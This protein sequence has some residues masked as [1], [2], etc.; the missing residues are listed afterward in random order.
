MIGSAL[1]I[2]A[3][4]AGIAA[5]YFIQKLIRTWL[6]RWTRDQDAK[7]LEQTKLDQEADA[8]RLA[9]TVKKQMDWENSETGPFP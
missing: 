2:V 5:A 7:A 9:D 8:K 6:G 3:S 1:Q 4:L